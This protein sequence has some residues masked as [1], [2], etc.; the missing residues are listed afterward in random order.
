MYVHMHD[1]DVSQ[2]NP[3]GTPPRGNSGYDDVLQMGM[4]RI[5]Q[6]GSQLGADLGLVVGRVGRVVASWFSK[7]NHYIS[8]CV[9]EIR[10]SYPGGFLGFHD[11][12]NLE[13]KR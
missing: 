12:D 1:H 4:A 6:K 3:V 13:C 11:Q 5:Q 2:K 9:K 8:F 10:M 7:V